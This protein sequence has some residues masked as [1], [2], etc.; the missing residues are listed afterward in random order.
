MVDLGGNEIM[1]DEQLFAFLTD[2][3]EMEGTD[4]LVGYITASLMKIK[5][6]DE[7]KLENFTA[8]FEE[9]K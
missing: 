5:K 3:L 4:F 8:L 7:T 6:M 2:A 1:N 9:T